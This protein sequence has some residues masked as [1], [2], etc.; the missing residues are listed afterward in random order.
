LKFYFTDLEF[1]V[2]KDPFLSSD[3]KN[4]VFVQPNNCS[5]FTAEKFTKSENPESKDGDYLA[6]FELD[7]HLKSKN[8]LIEVSAPTSFSSDEKNEVKSVKLGSGI[9]PQLLTYFP[10]SFQLKI[11]ATEGNVKV[12]KDKRPMARA[13]VKSFMKTKTGLIKFWKDGYT[14]LRGAFNFTNLGGSAAG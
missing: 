9:K 4:F 11:D 6:I 7:D 12:F 1:L 8:L 2:S 10:V 13:Y 14:D 3:M 5:E